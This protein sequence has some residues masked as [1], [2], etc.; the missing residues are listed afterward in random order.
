[1]LPLQVH[2]RQIEIQR[3]LRHQRLEIVEG[4]RMA[5]FD[6]PD[7]RF[8][9]RPLRGSHEPCGAW[10]HPATDHFVLHSRFDERPDLWRHSFRRLDRQRDGV[11][12][13]AE[14]GFASGLAA[15]AKY[16]RRRKHR[17]LF[18]ESIR[19]ELD[20]VGASGVVLTVPEEVVDA[21]D[22]EGQVALDGLGPRAPGSTRTPSAVMAREARAFSA[23]TTS[24]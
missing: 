8:E 18:E 6:D 13:A 19:H 1:M 16:R 23:A 24:G 5:G 17:Q 2:V 21:P 11:V 7:R 12:D 4:K 3:H 10:R 20:E 9:R 15:R 22:Q 14:I